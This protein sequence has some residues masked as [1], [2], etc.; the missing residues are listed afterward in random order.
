MA[1]TCGDNAIDESKLRPMCESDVH[2]KADEDAAPYA[3][4]I[5]MNRN[6]LS[7]CERLLAPD[8]FEFSVL[9]VA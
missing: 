3:K 6:T 1:S 7:H 4:V 8:H 9:I 5:L 2:I